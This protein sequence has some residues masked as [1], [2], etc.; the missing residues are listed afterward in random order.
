MSGVG[1]LRPTTTR[2]LVYGKEETEVFVATSEL[3]YDRVA[4]NSPILDSISLFDTPDLD[5]TN[6]ENRSRALD[7]IERAH[8]VVF[9]TS[10]LRYADLV[11]WEVFRDIWDRGVPIVFVL[12]RV[13]SET[14]G[15]VTDFRR[16]VRS[17]G[18]SLRV[19]RVEEHLVKNGELLPPASVRELRRAILA[20]CTDPGT[21]ERYLDSGL[22]YV[23]RV[24]GEMQSEMAAA[25]AE[26]E[27]LGRLAMAFTLDPGAGFA[28]EVDSWERASSGASRWKRRKAWRSTFNAVLAGIKHEL[29]GIVEANLRMTGVAGGRTVVDLTDSA[30]ADLFA[31]VDEA[32]ES[33]LDQIGDGTLDQMGFRAARE[34]VRIAIESART[35]FGLGKLDGTDEPVASATKALERSI[36]HLFG[37]GAER[38]GQPR[39][40]AEQAA[41]ALFLRSFEP[42]KRSAIAS[43]A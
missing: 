35:A 13:S 27:E 11:P 21:R 25:D 29:I 4:G 20:A 14:A 38:F 5:S 19:I 39:F 43:N 41:L 36:R 18:M 16:R 26:R 22:S 32:I 17:E 31:L 33:W 1:V 12:N 40:E 34:K 2:P 30:D 10:A 15:V 3:S 24:L 42:V 8:L 23:S 9:V 37:F 28:A 6:L 7:A